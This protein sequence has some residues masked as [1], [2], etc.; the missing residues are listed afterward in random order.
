MLRITKIFEAQWTS[1]HCYHIWVQ[2]KDGSDIRAGRF[3]WLSQNL[4]EKLAWWHALAMPVLGRQKQENP[5]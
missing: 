4:C 2:M 5:T 1:G 3:D